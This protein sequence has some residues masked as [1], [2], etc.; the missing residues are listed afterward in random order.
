MANPTPEKFAA[1]GMK[2]CEANLAGTLQGDYQH[3]GVEWMLA[4]ECP[5]HEVLGG[6]L[7][8]DVGMGK[9]NMALAL[10]VANPLDK[11]TLIFTLPATVTHW[12]ETCKT[13]LGVSPMV[14]K[15]NFKGGMAPTTKVV[16]APYSMLQSHSGTTPPS[17]LRRPWGRLI[18]DEGHIIRNAATKQSKLISQLAKDITWVLTA[19]PIQNNIKDLTN[20][21]RIIGIND[22]D[23]DTIISHYYLRRTQAEVGLQNPEYALPSLTT[24]VRLP[25]ATALCPANYLP[26]CPTDPF[27]SPCAPQVIK[28][29]FEDPAEELL[30]NTV[31]DLFLQRLEAAETDNAKFHNTAIEGLTRLRQICAHPFVFFKAIT[32]KISKKQMAELMRAGKNSSILRSELPSVPSALSPCDDAEFETFLNTLFEDDSDSDEPAAKARKGADGTRTPSAYYNALKMLDGDDNSI[33]ATEDIITHLAKQG[34]ELSSH[35]SMYGSKVDYLVN[36]ILKQRASTSA[37]A[38]TPAARPKKSLVFCSFIEEMK[39]ISDVLDSN[40]ISYVIFDGSMDRNEKD[41]AI[42]NFQTTDVEVMVLQV[43]CGSTGLNLQ[44][45]SRVYIMTPNY[46]PCVDIQAVGRSHRK[47][48]T[49]AVECIRLVIENTVDERCLTISNDKLAVIT[50]A[51]KDDDFNAKLGA[52]PTAAGEL[53]KDDLMSIF[54]SKGSKKEVASNGSKG[55]GKGKAK[56]SK[57]ATAAGSSRGKKAVKRTA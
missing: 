46:N 1:I 54:S 3:K 41:M 47:G 5:L 53:T 12:K 11:P 8:D 38:S 37:T 50:A 56:G 10:L 31:H 4:R 44:A 15:S 30:Y 25:L 42:E 17:I 18:M 32:A 51:L 49:D 35:N 55:K 16:I 52:V 24:K 26:N 13:F 29:P 34:V 7:C 20:L 39:L 33:V 57:K 6:F 36:D 9:T 27:P 43:K 14:L 2:T 28:I 40:N 22:T 19:T 48:Q 23:P 21:A 45:A